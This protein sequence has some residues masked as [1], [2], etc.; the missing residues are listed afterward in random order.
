MAYFYEAPT[1]EQPTPIWIEQLRAEK[2][3]LEA[4]IPP[5][6]LGE[7]RLVKGLL[8]ILDLQASRA[9]CA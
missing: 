1:E 4:D 6:K 9:P 5:E 8:H 2:A 7:Y 3:E